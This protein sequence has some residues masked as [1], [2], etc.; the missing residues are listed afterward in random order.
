MFK[1]LSS[2]KI[3]LN[4]FIK[5]ILTKSNL[6][7]LSERMECSQKRLNE[8]R[9]DVLGKRKFAGAH[10]KLRKYVIYTSTKFIIFSKDNVNAVNINPCGL[11]LIL[12]SKSVLCRVSVSKSHKLQEINK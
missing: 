8:I 5:A 12:L 3:M 11:C 2:E 1:K 4:Y 10:M 7:L 6:K 9:Y